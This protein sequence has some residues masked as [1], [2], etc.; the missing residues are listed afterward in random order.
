MSLHA[1][2]RVVFRTLL[3]SILLSTLLFAGVPANV[4][5]AAGNADGDKTDS[6][7]SDTQVYEPGGEVTPPKLIHYVEPNFSSS[8]KEAFVEGTV[9]IST[10]VKTD[11]SPIDLHVLKGLNA[12][13]DQQAVEAV[14]QWRFK[15]GAKK[16]QPVNVRVTVEVDFHLL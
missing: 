2:G 5:V 10:V 14:T 15:P 8:S 11:G 13:E 3:V 6:K 4:A 7:A 1:S 9:R 16:G 12:E